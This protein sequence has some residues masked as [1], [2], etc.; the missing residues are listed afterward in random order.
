MKITNKNYITKVRFSAL[1][2]FFILVTTA[3]FI[4]TF[5][6]KV[7]L[8]SA[9]FL[10]VVF[11]FAVSYRVY[12]FSGECLTFRKYTLLTKGYVRPYVEIPASCIKDYTVSRFLY[13]HYISL[14]IDNGTAAPKTISISLRWFKESQISSIVKTIEFVEN[15]YN[16]NYESSEKRELRYAGNQHSIS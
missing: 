4:S 8:V 7:I 9:G 15:K 5:I 11:T 16:I 14:S 3:L 6:I 12:E 13:T 2:L 10:L 1:S